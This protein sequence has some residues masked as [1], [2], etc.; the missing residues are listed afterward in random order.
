MLRLERK[1]GRNNGS[2]R[3][4]LFVNSPEFTDKP[5]RACPWHPIVSVNTDDVF[6]CGLGECS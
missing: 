6:Q 3:T 1:V 4:D 2:V 5:Y